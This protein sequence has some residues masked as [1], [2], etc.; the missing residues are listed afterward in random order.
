MAEISRTALT[1]RVS[2]VEVD[3]IY[4]IT[5]TSLIKACS[6]SYSF[7]EQFPTYVLHALL[8]PPHLLIS[9]KSVI[10]TVFY[11]IN[12]KKIPPTHPY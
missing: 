11:V 3:L 7:L 8:E 1:V 4:Q 5:L 9:E 2:K 6:K 12:F 10:Y